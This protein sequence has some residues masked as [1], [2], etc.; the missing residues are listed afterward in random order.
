MTNDLHYTRLS[1]LKRAVEAGDPALGDGG[2]IVIPEPMWADASTE[3]RAAFEALVKEKGFGH[4]IERRW[5][6]RPPEGHGITSVS[7][8][9]DG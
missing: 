7:V 8:E 9:R 4:R 5:Q 6:R 1:E 2:T 3:T